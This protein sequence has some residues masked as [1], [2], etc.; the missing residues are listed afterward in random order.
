[1]K[2]IAFKSVQCTDGLNVWYWK[3]PRKGWVDRIVVFLSYLLSLLKERIVNNV[4]H[5]NKSTR[6]RVSK[7]VPLTGRPWDRLSSYTSSTFLNKK[8]SAHT[9]RGQQATDGVILAISEKCTWTVHRGSSDSISRAWQSGRLS[10]ENSVLIAEII[11]TFQVLSLVSRRFSLM[12]LQPPPGH[13]DP[14][15]PERKIPSPTFFRF[16]GLCSMSSSKPP[17]PEHRAR[18]SINL[19][20]HNIYRTPSV[21]FSVVDEASDSELSTIQTSF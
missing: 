20:N 1:M 2:L 17:H 8:I 16:F 19:G 14:T 15:Q 6:V 9:R 5:N 11:I 21:N 18:R 7:Y 3:S 4:T 13:M 10:G 12:P